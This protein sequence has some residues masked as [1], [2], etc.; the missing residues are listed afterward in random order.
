[1]KQGLLSLF[2]VLIINAAVVA[3][4]D[5]IATATT[6]LQAGNYPAAAV[7]LD[8]VLEKNPESVDALMMKGNLILNKNLSETGAGVLALQAN[9][10]ESIY[11]SG[12]GTLGSSPV[13]IETETAKQV[14]AL[15]KKCLGIEPARMDIH[16]GLCTLYSKA[17][18]KAELLAALENLIKAAHARNDD[19][20]YE[21]E[22]YALAFDERGRFDDCMDIYKFIAER[23]PKSGGFVADM[24]VMY[25]KN[26]HPAEA[27]KY[28]RLALA[29]EKLDFLSV[30]SCTAII[31][32][33]EG[34]LPAIE[35]FEKGKWKRSEPEFLFYKGVIGFYQ[36]NPDYKK[37]LAKFLAT[38]FTGNEEGDPRPEIA[39]LMSNPAF[40]PDSAAYYT[41]MAL[42]P[43]ELEVFL[44]SEKACKV[45]KD[46]FDPMLKL[47]EMYGEHSC[48]EQANKWLKQM[49]N[50]HRNAGQDTTYLFNLAYC[51]Y[52]SGDKTN[53]VANWKQLQ[54]CDD[55]FIQS[56]AC[57]FLGSYYA[58][59]G[60]KEEAREVFTRVSG[61]P[62]QTKFANLCLNKLNQLN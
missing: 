1:M 45:L 29:N 9:N 43:Y 7:Y 18:M 31:A 39:R 56:A 8:S 47:I 54:H 28:A 50:L 46:P 12:M 48:F 42:Q 41:I 21:L 19:F 30:Y 5:V 58:E 51:Q 40:K 14:A 55:F 38:G 23:L 4:N 13:I 24:A 62:S 49:N 59:Q 3:Q 44:L 20:A 60:K 11:D 53:A 57:Y 36:G 22:D 33:A 52:K 27:A 61:Q 15:W 25:F 26:N 6:L 2:L 35:L 17:L 16:Q 32:H 10:D 34:T 37:E